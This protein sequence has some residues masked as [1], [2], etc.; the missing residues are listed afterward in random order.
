MGNRTSIDPEMAHRINYLLFEGQGDELF[1]T[2]ANHI[3]HSGLEV[4]EAALNELNAAVR[5]ARPPRLGGRG[6]PSSHSNKR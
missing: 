5:R 4:S 2:L 6:L 1:K 3:E